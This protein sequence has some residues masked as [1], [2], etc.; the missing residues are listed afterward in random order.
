MKKI[1][2]TEIEEF[3]FGHAQDMK[4]AT[5]CTVIINAG[6]AIGG[7]D[8]RGGS[9]GTRET[10]LLNPQNL[11][12][13]VHAVFLSGGSAY[14]LDV[15]SGVMKFL[16]EQD[17]GFDVQVA[18]VPIVTGAILFDLYP[19]DPTVRPDLKMGYEAAQNAFNKDVLKEGSIGA[20]TGATVG[21]CLG[22]NFAM[23]G[24]LGTYAVQIG[25]LKI[26]AIVA[27][28]CFG[29]VVDPV[30]GDVIAGV[31]D[32]SNRTFLHTEDILLQQT[33]QS[34]KTNRFKGNTTIGTIVTNAKLTKPQANK[35]ASIAHDG[36]ARTMRPSHTLV[37]GDTIFTLSSNKVDAELNVVGMLAVNVVEQAVLNAV[38]EAK[39]VQSILSYQDIRE[40]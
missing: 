22:P 27:V 32:S 6:G 5:G 1:P 20:G 7:V 40:G 15:G 2:I 16:E 18:K 11:V 13:E 26:G 14:G 30:T 37:D 36:F 10:D 33:Q 8:V 25:D 17:I 38:K 19:G 3:Q 21:K 12:E 29:D 35:I 28:N 31:F 9:P 4:A 23:K 24:G 34:D 39:S